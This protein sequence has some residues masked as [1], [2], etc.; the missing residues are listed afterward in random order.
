MVLGAEAAYQQEK[1]GSPDSTTVVGRGSGKDSFLF[2][3]LIFIASQ[4]D[5]LAKL[6]AWIGT[7]RDGRAHLWPFGIFRA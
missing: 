3:L 6:P 2:L 5:G 4:A 7:R 1:A